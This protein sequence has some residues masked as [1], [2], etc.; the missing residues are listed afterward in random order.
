M[1]RR[2][3]LGRIGRAALAAGVLGVVPARGHARPDVCD[4]L[5]AAPIRWLV[6]WSP[7]GGYDT[8]SR[9]LEPVL[10]RELER[11]VVVENAP[12]A[13][14]LIAARR[15]SGARPDGHTLGILNG[16]GLLITPL[17][18]P[19]FSFD[20]A[21]DFTILARIARQD[22][23]LFLGRGTGI[24]TIEEL[25]ERT[26]GGQLVLG[27]TGFGTVNLLLAATLE[28]LFGMRVEQVLGFAGSSEVI[29][30]VR[31]G[32]VDGG[33]ISEEGIFRDATVVPLLRFS[34]QAAG[35]SEL[36]AIPRLE[37]SAGLI[38]TRPELFVD[39]RRARVD[40]EALASVTSVGRLLAGPPGLPSDLEAC[41]IGA[42][43][44]V[45]GD[46]GFVTAA[47]RLGRGLQPTSPEAVA[48]D[49]ASAIAARP[50]FEAAIRRALTRQRG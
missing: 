17:S 47:G 18:N 4:A 41:L 24:A 39:P 33:V 12:G 43:A 35:D 10:E 42:V 48:R 5:G 23:V 8:Y 34:P 6:G 31:Q 37:G 2:E 19:S 45:L 32:W 9:L 20:I 1:R 25:V 30:A 16:T 22:Q 36:S 44:R 49:L 40:A 7:G 28:D 21:S 26:R 11:E 50:R 3:A 38:A 14:G 13:A 27:G 29:H 46:P 15:I